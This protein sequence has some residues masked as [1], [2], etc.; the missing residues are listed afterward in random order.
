MLLAS[1][2]RMKEIAMKKD[3]GVQNHW[4]R[5][6]MLCLRYGWPILVVLGILW[7]PFDW[8]SEVWPAFGVPFRQIFHNA[9]DHFV[10]HTIF[11]FIVGMLLLGVVPLLRKLRWYLPG[12]VLAALVQETIQAFFRG[13]LPTFTDFNAFRGDALGGISAWLL[14]FLFQQLRTYRTKRSNGERVS[15]THSQ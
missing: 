7:F 6:A 9:R 11:F 8:L 15:S 1:V 2:K 13:Q 12:L 5:W 4:R 10:G 3:A 14:W